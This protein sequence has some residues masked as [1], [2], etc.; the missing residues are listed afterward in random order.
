[1]A[2]TISPYGNEPT[3]ISYELSNYVSRLSTAFNWYNQEKDKKD[4]RA[5]L[6]NYASSFD[7]H[8][9]K[10]ID[11]VPDQSIIC[12]FGWLARLI[13]TGSTLAPSHVN[14]LKEYVSKLLTYQE[15]LKEVEVVTSKPTVRENMEVKVKEFL[16]E[17][18]G[19]LDEQS[20][21][22][23]FQNM[24]N[25]SIPAAYVPHVMTFVQRKADE[26][27][28]VYETELSDVKEGYS[29]FGKR[30]FTAVLKLLSQWKEDLERY[31]QFKKAN[32]KPRARKVKPAIEQVTKV[33]YCKVFPELNLTSLNPVEL[34]GASQV[35]LYNVKYKKLAVY[36]TES[37]QGIQVKGT[38][39]QNYDP[40]LCE[41]KTLRK[42]QE[43]IKEVL[44]AGKV[45]LR[46]V[47]SSLSTKPSPVNGR[48][49]E[50]T[51]ILRVIK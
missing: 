2:K 23:L 16:G 37:S 11:R 5:F 27:I 6:K 32:K 21:F 42:P 17:L 19:A 1:M 36:R 3:G 33:K 39:L 24:Q 49:N 47:L 41:Q 35:W 10:I 8:G 14:E 40:E 13:L 15:P 46:K 34:V 48:I 29:N 38:T 22:N 28:Y 44:Q 4:A 43:T 18:E 51:L 7:R 12:T 26:F 25:R 45:N 31:G 30:K 50:E 20:D 9:A